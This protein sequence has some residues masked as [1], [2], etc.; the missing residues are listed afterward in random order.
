VSAPRAFDPSAFGLLTGPTPLHPLPRL[1]EVLGGPEIWVKR[2]DLTPPGGGG[3][4][5]R[6]LDVILP[7]ALAEGCDTLVTAG[8]AQSNSVRQTAAAAA[9]AGLSCV[10]LCVAEPE[11]ADRVGG[12]PGLAELAGAELRWAPPGTDYATVLAELADGLRAEGR[13]PYTIP[14]GASSA[15]GNLGYVGAAEEITSQMA[16]PDIVAV[17]S[18]SGGTQAGLITGFRDAAPGTQVIGFSVS[19]PTESQVAK[20]RGHLRDIAAFAER[21]DWA[22]LPVTVDDRA[23][24]PGYALPDDATW[25]AITLAARTEGLLFDPTYTGKAMAGLIGR[26]RSG[27]VPRNATVLFL[28]TGGLPGLLAGQHWPR[29]PTPALE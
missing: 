15:L 17:A 29:G 10:A 28:H 8:A 3:N 4:K 6:K 5:V 7:D 2:D 1:S 22:D 24:G 20:V 23:L 26:I 13:R 14:V 21:P 19:G 12:N 16:A 25:E 27:E 9:R 18:G 11:G